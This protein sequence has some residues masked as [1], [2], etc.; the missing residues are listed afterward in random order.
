MEEK[1]VTSP[2]AQFGSALMAEARERHAK[3]KMD[4]A[5]GEVNRIMASIDKV[6]AE[7]TRNAE[8]LRIYRG[9]LACIETGRFEVKADG[10]FVYDGEPILNQPR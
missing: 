10:H 4:A 1:A 2:Q 9:R 8:T 6:E 7:Q 3:A 5:I